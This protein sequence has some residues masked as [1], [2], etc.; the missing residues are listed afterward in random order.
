MLREKHVAII[1][2]VVVGGCFFI[3]LIIIAILLLRRQLAKVEEKQ[4][5]LTA[6]ISG[7]IPCEVRQP[8]YIHCIE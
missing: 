7:V 4:L 8:T 2:G 6:K 1:V 5:R 3:G